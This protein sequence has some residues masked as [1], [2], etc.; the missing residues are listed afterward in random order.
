MSATK[1]WFDFVAK[2]GDVITAL[3]HARENLDDAIRF[4]REIESAAKSDDCG[5]LPRLG[6]AVAGEA[7]RLPKC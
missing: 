3:E 6:F 5:G 1:E 4:T 2:A 7:N